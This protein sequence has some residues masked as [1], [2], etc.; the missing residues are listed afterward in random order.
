VVDEPPIVPSLRLSIVATMFKSESYVD[1]FCRRASAAAQSLTGSYEIILVNDGSPDRSLEL[2]VGLCRIDPHIRVIDLS[3]NFGHHKAMMT[4]LAHAAGELVFLI[5]SDLEEEPEWLRLFHDTLEREQA[6]VV[7]GVQRSR[8][9]TLVA[10]LTGALYYATLNGLLDHPLPRNVITAR[11]MTARYVRQLIRHR[12]RA[13]AIA[14]LWVITGFRQIAMPVDKK[15]GRSL[16]YG[17]ADRVAA[18]VT[19]VTSFSARPLVF[20]FYLGCAI[21]ATA[22]AAAAWLIW[23]VLFYQVGVSGYPSLIISVWFLGGVTVFCLGV[24]GIYLSRVF[25]ETKD[26]PYSIVRAYY[27]E[28]SETPISRP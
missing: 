26:R 14:A 23:R 6:D 20:I 15:P 16:S 17:F 9:G 27:P 25:I 5:D 22:G 7:F 8:T 18:M 1:E 24:I 3:R 11:L 21:M 19:T 2:A 13:V 12:D 28:S 4:G 10:R